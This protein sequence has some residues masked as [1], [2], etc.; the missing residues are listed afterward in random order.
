MSQEKNSF[1]YIYRALTAILLFI[2]LTG[3]VVNTFMSGNGNFLP[4]NFLVLLLSALLLLLFRKADQFFKKCSL[5]ANRGILIGLLLLFALLEIYL[6]RNFIP[7][8]IHDPF[9]LRSFAYDLANGRQGRWGIYFAQYPQIVSPTIFYSW[10]VRLGHFILLDKFAIQ[11]VISF[12]LL[13]VFLALCLLNVYQA[14]K[15]IRYLNLTAMLF[16]CLPMLYSYNLWILYTDLPAMIT[17]ALALFLLQYAIEKKRLPWKLL[18]PS[19]VIF[20][21]GMSSKASFIVVLP[22]ILL[23]MLFLFYY[24]NRAFAPVLKLFLVLFAVIALS[25][26]INTRLANSYHFSSSSRYEFPITHWMSMGLN[27]VSAGQYN[28]QDVNQ[29]AALP[30]KSQRSRVAGRRLLNRIK[31]E[32]PLGLLRQFIQKFA[33]LLYAGNIFDRYH[34]GFILAPPFYENHAQLINNAVSTLSRASYIA[35]FAL[36]FWK[37]K[38]RLFQSQYDDQ[39]SAAAFVNIIL[40]LAGLSFYALL[41]EVNGRYG[42]I[43]IL[44]I[45]LLAIQPTKENTTANKLSE[46][47]LTLITLILLTLVSAAGAAAAAFDI[48]LVN[49]NQQVIDGDPDDRLAKQTFLPVLGNY[50]NYG[51]GYD[52][53]D[54]RIRPGQSVSQAVTISG[55]RFTRLRIMR[56]QKQFGELTIRYQG[57]IIFKKGHFAKNKTWVHL[58][59]RFRPGRYLITWHNNTRHAIGIV[60]QAGHGYPLS[61]QPMS[62]SYFQDRYLIYTFEVLKK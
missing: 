45:L 39:A 24:R 55:S 22:A 37:L 23:L 28:Q 60:S 9:R 30:N 43:A 6:L 10:A 8:L 48:D 35:I 16:F 62:G 21:F 5:A 12:T 18:L 25:F 42:E 31:Q 27:Q 49:L 54:K 2:L 13:N 41:W 40:P 1:R 29:M 33:V 61:M 58:Q 26:P 47:R 52:R 46:S 44:P 15:K 20:Y 57:R 36:A 56:E 59:Y 19:A 51:A 38:K 7:S 3:V 50:S 34:T 32:G 11:S 14:T 53:E 4:G 17:W